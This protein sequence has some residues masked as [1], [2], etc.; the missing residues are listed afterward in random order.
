LGEAAARL[1][2]DFFLIDNNPDAVQI[3][4]RRLAF[5]EPECVNFVPRSLPNQQH[6]LFAGRK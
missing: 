5:A 6:L 1:G 4:A 3:M 2:R